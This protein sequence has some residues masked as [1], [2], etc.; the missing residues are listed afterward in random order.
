MEAT[1]EVID[2]FIEVHGESNLI[3]GSQLSFNLLDDEGNW[4]P[5]GG[6]TH[7]K[8]EGSF[9]RIIELPENAQ[10]LDSY[11]LVIYFETSQ[12]ACENVVEDYG[13]DESKLVG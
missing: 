8:P 5:G 1:A 12:Y 2:E 13:V 11:K 4:H 6:F 10:N 9:F 7:A 3:E